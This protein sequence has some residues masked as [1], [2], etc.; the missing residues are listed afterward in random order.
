MGKRQ[1]PDPPS[2]KKYGVP[3]YSVAWVPDHI[4]KLHQTVTADESSDSSH[5]S[6]PETK[7][8]PSGMYLVLAGGGGAGSS[9]I[10]NSVFLSHF[11]AASDSLSDQPVH[12]IFLMLLARF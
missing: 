1:V 12:L 2:L 10:P 8:Q 11:D 6:A 7:G 5:K 3:L 9:G 4:L